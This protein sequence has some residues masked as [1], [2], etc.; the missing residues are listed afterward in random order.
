[1]ATYDEIAT[2]YSQ[3]ALK[4][5]VTS[6]IG[7][8]ANNVIFEAPSTPN[9]AERYAWAARAAQNPVNE[10]QRFLMPVLTINNGSTVAQILALDDATIQ[11]NVDLFI[12]VFA[13][14]DAA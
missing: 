2:L 5:Q 7:Q 3:S 12:D 14:Y 10:A 11:G 13:L 8:A 1:M 6:A 9:H 4:P